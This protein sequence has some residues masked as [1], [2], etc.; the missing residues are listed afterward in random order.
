MRP[1]GMFF[2]VVLAAAL[3][4]TVWS[5]EKSTPLRPYGYGNA[6]GGACNH[7]YTIVGDGGG[8]LVPEL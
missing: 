5:E 3:P 8:E 2:A 6:A 7:G 1:R 4:G